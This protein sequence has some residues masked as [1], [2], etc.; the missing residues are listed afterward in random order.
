[1]DDSLELSSETAD[2][3]DAKEPPIPFFRLNGNSCH[4]DS[5]VA[6]SLAAITKLGIVYKKDAHTKDET[7]LMALLRSVQGSEPCDLEAIIQK[8]LKHPPM[9]PEINSEAQDAF[10]CFLLLTLRVG[11]SDRLRDWFRQYYSSNYCYG[12]GR[13]PVIGNIRSWFTPFSE[14]GICSK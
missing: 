5:T 2:P 12:Q 11:P 4:L 1:L 8:F 7:K 13:Y 10:V 9:Q 14:H 3:L 6:I